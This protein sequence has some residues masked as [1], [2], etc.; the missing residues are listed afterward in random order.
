MARLLL[1]ESAAVDIVSREVGFGVQTLER[2]LAYALAA[3]AGGQ[4]GAPGQCW[5]AVAR[6]EAVITPAAVEEATRNT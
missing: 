1:P 2:C 5:T 3:T 4:A 6:L